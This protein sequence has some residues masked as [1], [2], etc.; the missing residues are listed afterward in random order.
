MG[1]FLLSD[2]PESIFY[3]ILSFLDTKDIIRVSTLS[4]RYRELCFSLPFLNAVVKEFDDEDEFSRFIEFLNWFMALDF[5]DGDDYSMI[6]EVKVDICCKNL[7]ID[8][9]NVIVSRVREAITRCSIEKICLVLDGIDTLD[10]TNN[11][12]GSESLRELEVKLGPDGD[13]ILPTINPFRGLVSLTLKLLRVSIQSFGEWISSCKKLKM[14]H[15]IGVVFMDK[16]LNIT[17]SSLEDLSIVNMKQYSVDEDFYIKVSAERLKLL[18]ILWPN[19]NPGNTP[20]YSLTLH[21]PNLQK[22]SWDGNVFHYSFDGKFESLLHSYISILPSPDVCKEHSAL[23]NEIFAKAAQTICRVSSICIT[24]HCVEEMSSRGLLPKFCNLRSLTLIRAG[25]CNNITSTV[26]LLNSTP[27]LNALKIGPK[28]YWLLYFIDAPV[29]TCY[30]A[31]YWESQNLEFVHSLQEVE[32][33]IDGDQEEIE[34]IKFLL[35][36]A[37]A[38]KKMTVRYT[39]EGIRKHALIIA[40]VQRLKIA[41]SSITIDFLPK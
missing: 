40:I 34:L 18:R 15:L 6:K 12:L 39:S 9:G 8:I 29:E 23:S 1:D 27:H 26:D 33:K 32:I 10:L 14:L 24:D 2:L 3:R 22:F 30:N 31:E 16:E 5:G 19:A 28:P 11:V 37:K 41:S 20:I 25:L 38:L 4:R 17:S 7:G 35:K 13:L 36:K 21:A